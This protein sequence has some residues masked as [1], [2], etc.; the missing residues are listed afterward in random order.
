M[1]DR[2]RRTYDLFRSLV[3]EF[4]GRGFKPLV[5][6]AHRVDRGDPAD[7]EH[8]WFE[9][10]DLRADGVTAAP[11]KDA[12]HVAA[13]RHGLPVFTP[14]EQLTDWAIRSPFGTMTPRDLR[15]ARAARSGD[16]QPPL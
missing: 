1:A 4:A 7:L 6:L 16:E 12:E 5:K 15:S 3:G 11:A 2:A 8:L 10:A 13:L 9:V 14:V